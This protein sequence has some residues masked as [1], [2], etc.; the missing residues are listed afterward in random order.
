MCSL[1]RLPLTVASEQR[2]VLRF[3][4]PVASSADRHR[5]SQA[6]DFLPSPPPP[7]P[8][9]TDRDLASIPSPR[10]LRHLPLPPPGSPLV[11]HSL[12]PPRQPHDSPADPGP[13]PPGAG[14]GARRGALSGTFVGAQNAQTPCSRTLVSLSAPLFAPH[15]LALSSLRASRPSIF[16]PRATRRPDRR[17]PPGPSAGRQDRSPDAVLLATLFGRDWFRRGL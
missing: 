2:G 9:P 3:R 10:P 12:P 1:R 4:E 7:S 11:P 15:G 16:G 17:A 13:A 14:A 6:G 8:S 5:R